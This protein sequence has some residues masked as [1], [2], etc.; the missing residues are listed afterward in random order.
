MPQ[1]HSWKDCRVEIPDNAERACGGYG[2]T[3]FCAVERFAPRK[4]EM[5]PICFY[6]GALERSIEDEAEAV[7]N[8]KQDPSPDRPEETP[9]IRVRREAAIEK[10][11]GD[12][13]RTRAYYGA[14]EAQPCYLER[15]R[16]G[17]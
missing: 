5:F 13:G 10:E 8:V 16:C 9:R 11:N 1:Q 12:F 17:L 15:V 4:I 3:L 7:C 2:K 6:G 14:V